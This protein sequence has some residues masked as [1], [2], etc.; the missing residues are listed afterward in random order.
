MLMSEAFRPQPVG[1][2]AQPVPC[3]ADSV[4]VIECA[5]SRQGR[6]SRQRWTQ[7]VVLPVGPTTIHSGKT[8]IRAA[9]IYRKVE[10][11]WVRA[12]NSPFIANAG[13][14]TRLNQSH[15]GIYM[16]VESESAGFTVAL[17]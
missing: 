4:G 10:L 9:P 5:R 1:A 8:L 11:T 6:A 16:V 3:S 2:R 17:V 14:E 12:T 15:D 13:A 7:D